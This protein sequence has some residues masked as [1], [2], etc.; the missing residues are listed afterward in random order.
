M[1]LALQM[2]QQEEMPPPLRQF[3][4]H[5]SSAALAHTESIVL[6]E[7]AFDGEEARDN[8]HRYSSE[9]LSHAAT[10]AQQSIG[11]L[12]L[13]VCEHL[14]EA[15]GRCLES[16]QALKCTVDNGVIYLEDCG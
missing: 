8:A 13:L 1:I 9:P 11:L 16:L 14:V 6:S 2:P 3:A 10:A 7:P 15:L 12:L 4:P 5:R